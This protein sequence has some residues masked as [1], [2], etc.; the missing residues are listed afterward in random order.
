MISQNKAGGPL[1]IKSILNNFTSFV[2][3]VY[4]KA[5]RQNIKKKNNKTIT[6]GQQSVKLWK[7]YLQLNWNKSTYSERKKADFLLVIGK[8][9]FFSKI[10]L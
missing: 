6:S 8:I 4:Q 1:K 3:Q 5:C 7:K 2:K 10:Q 9:N